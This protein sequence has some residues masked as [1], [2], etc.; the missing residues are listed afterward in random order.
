MHNTTAPPQVPAGS[1][2]IYILGFLQAQDIQPGAGQCGIAGELMPL[3]ATL[4]E[5]RTGADE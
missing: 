2:C 3:G 1:L 5:W 4:K